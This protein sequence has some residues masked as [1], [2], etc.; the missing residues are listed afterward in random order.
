MGGATTAA[1]R[2]PVSLVLEG[3]RKGLRRGARVPSFLAGM[4][5]FTYT[6]AVEMP[7]SSPGQEQAP[8]GRRSGA[9]SPRATA[10]RCFATIEANVNRILHTE[11]ER[12]CS[13]SESRAFFSAIFE[14]TVAEGFYADPGR[15]SGGIPSGGPNEAYLSSHLQMWEPVE[16]Y[17][18]SLGLRLEATFRDLF[19]VSREFED[20]P[21]EHR[22]VFWGQLCDG[23]GP[24]TAFM[25]T[26]P[27]SHECFRYSAPMHILLSRSS[28]PARQRGDGLG[29]GG[30]ALGEEDGEN[31]SAV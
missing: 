30:D 10:V 6:P 8:E 20:S 21:T 16:R 4:R 22:R 29:G 2:A 25:L 9:F 15:S 12:L 3:A 5:P 26:V 17:L 23:A 19:G 1:V 7:I 18:E 24:V 28:V 14:R 11:W 31:P 27:H 13:S